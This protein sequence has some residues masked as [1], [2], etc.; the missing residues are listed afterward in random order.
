M[1]LHIRTCVR[2]LAF[3]VPIYV[4]A[5]GC[6][7]ASSAGASYTVTSYYYT[8]RNMR[9][10]RQTL[11]TSQRPILHGGAM[12]W[13]TLRI[14]ALHAGYCVRAHKEDFC[15]IQ[16]W[17]KKVKLIFAEALFYSCRNRG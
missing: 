14:T 12:V 10:L 13:V 5:S 3:Q 15:A 17:K 9:Y 8:R 4:G 11:A 7:R 1:R 16:R 2:L 6:V